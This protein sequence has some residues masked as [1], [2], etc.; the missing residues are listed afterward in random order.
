MGGCSSASAAGASCNGGGGGGANENTA[1]GLPAGVVGFSFVSLLKLNDGLLIGLADRTEGLLA[2]FV[3][4]NAAKDVTGRP[5]LSVG[6]ATVGRD[7]NG[8][9]VVLAALAAGP[10]EDLNA[11]LPNPPTK[12]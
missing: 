4:L 7:A 11:K 3:K 5:V 9:D 10:G 1:T 8:I 12:G 2:G 6:F